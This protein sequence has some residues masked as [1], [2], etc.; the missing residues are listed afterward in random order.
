MHS[1]HTCNRVASKTVRSFCIY[2]DIFKKHYLGTKN[3][4]Q[5]NAD[6]QEGRKNTGK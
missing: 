2:E 1:R 4:T 5:K 3:R 6:F